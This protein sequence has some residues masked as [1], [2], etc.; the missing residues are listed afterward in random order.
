MQT[1]SGRIFELLKERNMSQKEFAQRTGIAE[2]TISDWKKKKTNP[3]SDKILIICEVLG[4]TPYDLLSGAEHTGER[5]RENTTYVI[6]KGTELGI[7]V[8]SYQ[9]LDDSMQKKLL[10][11]MEALKAL[12]DEK[13]ILN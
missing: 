13:Q 1:I 8:E 3:V 7:L 2:S 12:Q 6:D 11:Y 4:V 10:G 5:R 9:N